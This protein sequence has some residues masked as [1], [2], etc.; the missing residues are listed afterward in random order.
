[1]GTDKLQYFGG[2]LLIGTQFIMNE[3]QGSHMTVTPDTNRSIPVQ[4][5][6]AK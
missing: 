2:G 5:Y 3:R 4:L 6:Q 1:M